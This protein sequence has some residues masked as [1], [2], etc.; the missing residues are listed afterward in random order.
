MNSAQSL[1]GKKLKELAEKKENLVLI[2]EHD[3]KFEPWPSTRLHVCI[4][5]LVEI[6][7]D[8]ELELDVDKIR[9]KAKETLELLKFSNYHHTMFERLTDPKFAHNEKFMGG[10]RMMIS[11]KEK[12]ECGDLEEG[13]EADKHVVGNLLNTFHKMS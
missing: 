6:T 3:I 10:I 2:E 12:I 4:E 13:A 11:T 7:H 1:Q 9:K 5:K 8:P